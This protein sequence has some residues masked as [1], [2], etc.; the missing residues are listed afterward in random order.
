MILCSYKLWINSCGITA[1]P[2]FSIVRI[3]DFTHYN[4]Y[5]VVSNCYYNLQFPEETKC[6][7]LFYIIY[8][9]F[10]QLKKSI[11]LILFSATESINCKNSVA[12]KLC[13]H[14]TNTFYCD[15]DILLNHSILLCIQQSKNICEW[16]NKLSHTA[17]SFR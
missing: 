11:S 10:R 9:G 4:R 7:A 5:V 15:Y 1:L 17:L 16:S 13:S 12:T 14:R 8:K 2:V 6:W 3:F